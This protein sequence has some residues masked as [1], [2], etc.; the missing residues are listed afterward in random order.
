MA[1][2]LLAILLLAAVSAPAQAPDPRQLYQSLNAI[3]V[4]RAQ[5]YYVRE[6]HLRREVAR[7]TF[8]E[9]K[10]A[11]L[12]AP[13]GKLSGAVFSGSGRALAVP[14][15]PVEKGSLARYLGTPLVDLE[16]TRAYVRF[17][18]DTAEEL[19]SL[20]RDAGAKPVNDPAF[21]DEWDATVGNLNP[22]HS[23]RILNDRLS[24]ERLPY[25]YAGLMSPAKGAFD[26]L[27]DARREEQVLIGQPQ[28]G[29]GRPRYAI[30]ASFTKDGEPRKPPAA[31]SPAGYTIETTIQPDGM[32][33]GR[34]E[35][36]LKARR[37]G[38]RMVAL[39]LSRF[40]SVQSVT[41]ADGR[42]L[43][44]FQNE[45]ISR[46]EIAERGNDGLFVVLPEAPR[47][48]Q[49]F[50]LRLAYRGR[51]ISN[52]G[53]NVYFVGER[54]SW[55][56]HVATLDEFATF[57]LTFR[58]PKRLR[59]AAT[60]I[61]VESA[62]ADDAGEWQVG[63]WR[64]EKPVPV[65]GFNLGEYVTVTIEGGTFRVDLYANKQLEQALLARFQRP[66]TIVSGLRPA[67]AGPRLNPAEAMART[68]IV[69]PPAPPPSPAALLKQLGQDVVDSIH[70]Y[71][72][73]A[74]S[75]PFERLAVSPIPSGFGQGWP[76]LLYLSTL[77]FLSAEAHQRAGL[78]QR[79]QDVFLEL[80][81]FHEVAHQWWGN[82]VGSSSYRDQWI[83]EGLA[84]Y[85]ALL[86]A[87]SKRPGDKPLHTWLERFRND[88]LTKPSGQQETPDEAGPLTLGQRLRASPMPGAY[89]SVIYGK[90]PWV[91]HMLRIMLREPN[92]ADPDARFRRLLQSL[93]EGHR[94]RALTNEDLQRAVEK[95]M[96]PAM[97]LENNKK[98]DWFFDQWVYGTGI[99]RYSVKFDA[100]PHAQ[101]FLVRGTLKQA[102]VPDSFVARVP[103]YVP[104][105]GA[106]PAL[107]GVVET[108][109]ADTSFEFI[110][111]TR[112]RKILIDPN[113]TLLSAV[114]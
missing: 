26:I 111:R 112:P 40:L 66:G 73:Y 110:S 44:F 7:L 50:V 46:N 19:L 72:K 49:E 109:G 77:S 102:D 22:W 17:T 82:L 21:A 76:G 65:A 94:Y 45:E 108:G 4:D 31:F 92:A 38:E 87:E 41:H 32:L 114:E 79:T 18:D 95:V 75:F 80:M 88:L 16:F 13:D 101:G 81:P 47:A 52:A 98:M 48:G 51:V 106:R 97:D 29:E 24:E 113:L 103:L 30:W 3:R 6:L 35:L 104:R 68:P 43:V 53:N 20:L 64:S 67:P 70:F 96:T 9:G 59:L 11:L 62:A 12:T 36:R 90:G 83:H 93:V 55:Y 10:L 27:I 89:E 107:L 71:E 91:F 58:W 105:T 34:T 28:W 100:K 8:A 85:F 56:P 86:Y 33:E 5:I 69:L 60:G 15:D 84:T 78:G 63:R 1:I 2:R 61:S 42:P 37:D 23:L 25:F 54:G 57:D 14:R 39:E 74:G 99:P